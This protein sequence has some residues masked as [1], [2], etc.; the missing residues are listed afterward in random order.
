[1]VAIITAPQIDML[2]NGNS[3]LMEQINGAFVKTIP[4]FKMGLMNA[5]NERRQQLQSQSASAFEDRMRQFG[6][7]SK[8][9]VQLSTAMAQQSNTTKTLE[10]MWDTIVS[11]IANYQHLRAEQTVKR[12]QAEQQLLTLRS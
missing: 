1:M 9:A 11:G 12:Q 6:G 4:V 10:E 7:A 3:E 5:V 2:R 8:E